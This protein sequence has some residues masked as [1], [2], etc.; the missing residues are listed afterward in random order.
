MICDGDSSRKEQCSDFRPHSFLC[1]LWSFFT[2]SREQY[3]V[4]LH[5]EHTSSLMAPQSTQTFCLQSK[6]MLCSW[7]KNTGSWYWVLTNQE[8][9]SLK[10]TM[11]GDAKEV[12]RL[13]LV[14]V[15]EPLWMFF[16]TFIS[17]SFSI[18]E[19]SFFIYC[20]VCLVCVICAC[21]LHE[22]NDFWNDRHREMC[23]YDSFSECF[24]CF[25]KRKF[26]HPR[27]HQDVLGHTCEPWTLW[28]SVSRFEFFTVIEVEYH[29]IRDN[30]CTSVLL[31][32]FRYYMP[33]NK[34]L[35]EGGLHNSIFPIFDLDQWGVSSV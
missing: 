15:T 9:P 25:K 24:F 31:S 8:R 1:R 21:L 32:V 28:S 35:W 26:M 5:R 23:G 13:L 14:S 34:L 20:T 16:P 29:M 6:G 18:Y 22:P 2:Q 33:V 10:L 27:D 12:F 17:V 30:W 7:S 19:K 11:S 3:G 4:R